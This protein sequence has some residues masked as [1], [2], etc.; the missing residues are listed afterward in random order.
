MH[1]R[2]EK[3]K[4]EKPSSNSVEEADSGTNADFARVGAIGPDIRRRII[5]FEEE[6][7]VTDDVDGSGEIKLVHMGSCT[8]ENGGVRCHQFAKI[9]QYE[10]C[11]DFL[12][13]ELRSF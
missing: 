8:V 3:D 5:G 13:D 2:A 12:S 4:I 6:E 1:E 11:E 7:R 10:A 9:V